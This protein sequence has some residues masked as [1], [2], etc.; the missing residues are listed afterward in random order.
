MPTPAEQLVSRLNSKKFE[1]ELKRSAREKAEKRAQRRRELSQKPIKTDARLVAW[2]DVLG[3]SHELQQVKTDADLQA[4]YRKM[5][6]VH[7]CFNK[8]SASDEPEER[9]QA[10][11]IMGRTVLALS[12]GLIV[13]AGLK[14]A[15]LDLMSP[16]DLLMSLVGEIIMAQSACAMRGIFLRGGISAGPFHFDNDI[17]LSPALVRA[18]KLE[19][20]RAVYPVIVITPETVAELRRLPGI[21]AHAEDSE[22]SLGYFLRF[23][24]PHQEKGERFYFLDYVRHMADPNNYSFQSSADRNAFFDRKRSPEERQRILNESL[25]KSALKALQCYQRQLITA[26]RQATSEKV[27]SKYRWL[28]RYHNRTLKSITSFYDPALIALDQ[29]QT[30]SPQP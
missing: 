27:R 8:E 30:Q 2:I 16:F 13:T 3:F 4:A 1:A 15:A 14:G 28:M 18:Y 10:N 11:K 6:F 25:D 20:K 19:S 26:Y 29:F 7:D 5:L 23:K 9:R 24:S 21:E 22:P 12:D 17:L